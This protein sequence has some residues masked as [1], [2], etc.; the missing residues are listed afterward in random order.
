MKVNMQTGSFEILL[1][2]TSVTA[3]RS[4]LNPPVS[5]KLHPRMFRKVVVSEDSVNVVAGGDPALLS[6]SQNG[7][8]NELPRIFIQLVQGS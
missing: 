5:K 4:I 7:R 3:Y 1:T 2:T 6:Q 8:Q